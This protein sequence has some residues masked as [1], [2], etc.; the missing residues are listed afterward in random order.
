[1][2]RVWYGSPMLVRLCW[3]AC[4]GLDVDLDFGT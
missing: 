2:N 3:F 4:A 1:M